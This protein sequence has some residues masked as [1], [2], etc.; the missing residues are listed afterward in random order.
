MALADGSIVRGKLIL[1][2]SGHGTVVGRHLGLRRNFDDP[3]L[4]KVAYFR[5]FENVERL[6]AVF[7]L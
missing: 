5:H 4:Q 6:P 1:D 3:E 2:A 7:Q